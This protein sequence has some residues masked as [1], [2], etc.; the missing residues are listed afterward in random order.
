MPEK[1]IPEA[2]GESEFLNQFAPISDASKTLN[3]TLS[4]SGTYADPRA[5]SESKPEE[6]YSTLSS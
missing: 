3:F 6:H 1:Q 4:K 2:S 5:S